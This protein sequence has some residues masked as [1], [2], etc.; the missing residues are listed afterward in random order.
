MQI[1][2]ILTESKQY[3]QEKKDLDDSNKRIT[4]TIKNDLAEFH[5]EIILGLNLLEEIEVVPSRIVGPDGRPAS[6]RVVDTDTGDTV[7]S[8]A[9]EEEARRVRNQERS[10]RAAA[11]ARDNDADRNRQSGTDNRSQQ[12]N[13]DQPN[14]DADR[15]RQRGTDSSETTRKRE[16]MRQAFRRRYG[17][18]FNLMRFFRARSLLFSLAN[19]LGVAVTIEAMDLDGRLARSLGIDTDAGMATN[20]QDL[21]ESYWRLAQAGRLVPGN[22][23][24]MSEDELNAHIQRN[25]AM[26]EQILARSYAVVVAAFVPEMARMLYRGGRAI[27]K[28]IRWLRSARNIATGIA[29]GVGA[30][31]GAGI[32]GLVTGV[33]TYIIGSAALWAAQLVLQR[34]GIA[35]TVI[36]YILQYL[37]DRDRGQFAETVGISLDVLE[38]YGVGDTVAGIGANAAEVLGANE[39]ATNLRNVER[40]LMGD[41]RGRDEADRLSNILNPNNPEYQG[42]EDDSGSGTQPQAAPATPSATPNAPTARELNLLPN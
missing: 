15:N 25:I 22:I 16:T 12:P 24:S 19:T 41:P 29:A 6:Y 33:I 4:E 21:L 27:I 20:H 3:L 10:A 35:D 9:D 23:E 40:D 42:A 14:N 37:Y 2:E 39:L 17:Q 7:G 31:L 28:L 11:S 26:Y 8:F 13:N 38:E 36:E 32:G 18:P 5:K 30:A 34:S 1:N